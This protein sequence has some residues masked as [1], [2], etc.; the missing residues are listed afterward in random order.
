MTTSVAR[1]IDVQ[2][3]GVA[4][5]PAI[6]RVDLSAGSTVASSVKPPDQLAARADVPAITPVAP[7]VTCIPTA[8]F[9]SSVLPGCKVEHVARPSLLDVGLAR[10]PTSLFFRALGRSFD[11][12]YPFAL[13]PEV[14]GYLINH[15]IAETVRRHSEHYRA[16]YTKQTEGTVNIEIRDDSLANDQA[17]DWGRALTRFESALREQVPDG[18]MDAM[19]PTY[20]TWTVESRVAA[21]ITFMDAASPYFRYAVVSTCGI[22][23]IRLLGTLEDWRKLLEA[24]RELAERFDAHLAGYFQRLLPVL[25]TLAA[26][27]DPANAVDNDF[28]ASIYKHR[29]RSG[30]ERVTGWI[31]EFVH[32]EKDP[33]SGALVE[34]RTPSA[35]QAGSNA[36]EK[37][38]QCERFATHVSTVP[39]IW[40]RLMAKYS[41][42]LVGGIL[43]VDNVDGFVTPALSYAVVHAS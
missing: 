15:E 24:A 29:S 4:A 16:L 41:M 10:P 19:L 40:K 36:A 2:I 33:S 8:T 9:L 17:A 38:I 35:P 28:W 26:Q 12:H 42:R 37:S 21:L 25:T 1:T 22:P 14:L 11:R 18:I 23:R 43:G 32:Y 30:D 27:A 31:T 6:A 5:P 7:P 13:A 20:S 3:S 34:P 39:F